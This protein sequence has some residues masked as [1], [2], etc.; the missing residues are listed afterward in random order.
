MALKTCPHC[1][2]SV[3]DQAIKC[4]SCGKDPRYTDFQLEQ[5]E[6]Q[7]KKKRRTVGIIVAILVVIIATVCAIFLP[8]RIRYQKGIACREAKDYETAVDIFNSLGS[9]RD[10]DQMALLSMM[11]YIFAHPTSNDPISV[12]YAERLMEAG[13]ATSLPSDNPRGTITHSS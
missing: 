4:P 6:Q 13:Y 9:Y 12:K 3:S 10:S 5:Q 11:D 8:N 7:R 1:G 2:H